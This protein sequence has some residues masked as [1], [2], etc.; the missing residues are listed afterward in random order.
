[1][2]IICNV[3]P[4]DGGRTKREVE[5]NPNADLGNSPMAWPATQKFRWTLE[6]TVSG[7]DRATMEGAITRALDKWAEAT[8][9]TFKF[10]FA[11]SDAGTEPPPNMVISVVGPEGSDSDFAE[12]RDGSK[13]AAA[14]RLGPA[15]ATNTL[16]AETNTFQAPVKLNDS[17]TRPKWNPFMFHNCFLHE[18]GHSLGLGHTL[19]EGAVMGRSYQEGS[20]F[21]LE[22]VDL[23]DDD[24]KRMTDYFTKKNKSSS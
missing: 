10:T 5:D 19:T 13:V 14:A 9:D 15:G 3:Y 23:A 1:M 24:K 4:P 7:L 21:F 12:G 16:D 2:A 11:K 22:D 6:N 17:P 8:K 18:V 20:K